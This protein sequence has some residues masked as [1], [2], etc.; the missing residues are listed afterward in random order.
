MS[1]SCSVCGAW[2]MCLPC[3]KSRVMR[4]AWTSCAPAPWAWPCGL[5]RG[6]TTRRALHHMKECTYQAANAPGLSE[7]WPLLRCLSRTPARID[8]K[9][10]G[11]LFL[12]HGQAC[13]KSTTRP[14]CTFT[15]GATLP[16]RMF[17]IDVRDLLGS[18]WRVSASAAPAHTQSCE[19]AARAVRATCPLLAANSV[20]ACCCGRAPLMPALLDHHHHPPE[21]RRFRVS[22][23]CALLSLHI[24][25]APC[26]TAM[27]R[28]ALQI[29]KPGLCPSR[30][31]ACWA[32]SKRLQRLQTAVAAAWPSALRRWQAW[33]EQACAGAPHCCA[34]L[35]LRGLDGR[36][37]HL[38]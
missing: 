5:R 6:R 1:R 31:P 16:G 30:T 11:H 25:T 36:I 35:R 19:C 14:N 20:C 22:A 3:P 9:A 18:D 10:A 2:G 38:V 28:P 24:T 33:R 7:R 27:Q 34:S 12:V 13:L 15:G 21:A 32:Q 8:P 4:A 23:H 29:T 26:R 37:E 17:P